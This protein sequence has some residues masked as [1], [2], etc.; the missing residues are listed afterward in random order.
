MQGLGSEGPQLAGQGEA[1][2]GAVLG[3]LLRGSGRK[4][5][6]RHE[7]GNLQRAPQS[8]SQQEEL[9]GRRRGWRDQ[10]QEGWIKERVRWA[11]Q[12][13][14]GTRRLQ[15]EVKKCTCGAGA[16]GTS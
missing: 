5:L 15:L 14:R 8:I 16:K 10:R 9:W 6:E 13:P 11:E 4:L 3:E 2:S 1:S 7:L 12:G